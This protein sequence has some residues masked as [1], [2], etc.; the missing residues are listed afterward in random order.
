MKSK[1]T[2]K[3]KLPNGFKSSVMAITI[4]YGIAF[5]GASHAIAITSTTDANALAAAIQGGGGL[6]I[7]S[8]TLS[9]HTSGGATSSG[10]YTNASGTYGIGDG[11]VISSGNVNDYND[12]PNSSG[13]NTTS[14]GVGAT[15]AQ[16]ALLFPIS[17]QASHFDVTQFDVQFTT[18]TGEVFFLVT[19]GSDEF[20]EFKNSSFIDAFG[21]YLN[22]VNIATYNGFPVNIN[23]PDMNFCGGTE[24]DGVLT[25]DGPM[26]F[27]ASGL[28]TTQQHSLTFIIAD[29]GDSILDSTA[30]ISSLSGTSP[31]PEPASLALMGLGLAGLAAMRRRK[32]SDKS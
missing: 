12:G 25:C 31:V 28:D 22:G 27:S 18:S 23:H 19:F 1:E 30:Y 24:L 9:G 3:T 2:A 10:T 14:Y 32:E 4:A 16:Q 26:L 17:G 11:I 20:A 13:S 8:A 15:A 21:L 6:N 7:I 29:S 5:A